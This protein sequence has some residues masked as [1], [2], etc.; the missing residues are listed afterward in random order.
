MSEEGED[1]HEPHRR[2]ELRTAITYGKQKN[3]QE[4][5]ICDF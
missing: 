1:N 4:D 2:V 5:P 3:T